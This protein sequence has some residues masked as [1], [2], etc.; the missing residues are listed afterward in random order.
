MQMPLPFLLKKTGVGL[1]SLVY[2]LGKFAE[3][4]ARSVLSLPF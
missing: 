1:N 2:P 3:R 4:K